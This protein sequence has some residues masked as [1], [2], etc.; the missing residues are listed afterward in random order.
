MRMS[1]VPPDNGTDADFPRSF[2]SA[3]S[4]E[5]SYTRRGQTESESD[6]KAGMAAARDLASRRRKDVHTLSSSPRARHLS[7]SESNPV[8]SFEETGGKTPMHHHVSDNSTRTLIQKAEMKQR[9]DAAFLY[10]MAW[11]GQVNRP[12]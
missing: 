8:D 11:V 12:H 2:E 1:G 9:S 3:S 4:I 7:L 10:Q 5:S 6:I